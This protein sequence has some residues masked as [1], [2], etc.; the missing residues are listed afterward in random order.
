MSGGVK[1]KL[2]N[3][4]IEKKYEIILQLEKGKKP[5]DLS[6]QHGIPANTI[7]G[8]KKKTGVIKETYE[9]SVF[10]PSRKKLRVAKHKDLEDA[11]FQWF[12]NTRATNL[13]VNGP[14][15]ME[16]ASILAAKLGH[17]DF[18][19]CQ[20]WLDRFKKRH[21]IVFKAICG[22]ST[23]VQ[24]EQWL[25]TQM[26]RILD[27]Y[28]IRNIFNADETAV[29]W[30]C[31]PEK[32][33]RGEARHGGKNSKDRLTVLVAANI[34]GSQKLPLYVIGKSKNPRCFK[35]TKVLQ[36]DYD[37]QPSASITGDLFSAWVKKWDR[38][39]QA[40]KRKV[41]LIVDNCRAYPDVPG[42]KAIKIFYPPPNTTGKL[43]PMDQGIIQVLKVHYR[44]LLMRQYLLHDKKKAQ[45]T[46]SL[47]DAINF[48]RSAWNDVKKETISNCWMHCVIPDISGGEQLAEV[49][50]KSSIVDAILKEEAQELAITVQE[51]RDYIEI[52]KD[53]VT[54]RAITDDDIVSSVQSAQASTSACG[55]HEDDEEDADEDLKPIPSAVEVVEMLQKIRR[56]GSFVGDETVLDSINNIEACVFKQHC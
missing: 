18:K 36:C 43:Q 40:E 13:P 21:N 6:R 51:F 23:A 49:Q 53:V 16:K 3:Q 5:A 52:D 15:L 30:K 39:F 7:S 9:K 47:R 25:K 44:K 34:D 10:D 19:A 54:R 41:A 45:Y 33:F 50:E 32:A 2:D 28:E 46:P 22:E 4:S 56:Y 20:G 27:T 11:V 55:N 42:L 38:K 29:F 35:R 1:R 31:L 48:L 17:P 37:S 26:R 24:R 14:L 8:W 12:T